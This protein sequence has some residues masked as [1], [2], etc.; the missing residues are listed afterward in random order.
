MKKQIKNGILALLCLLLFSG[1]LP[2]AAAAKAGT[3]YLAAFS[4]NRTLIEPVSVTYTRG[5]SVKDAL[6]ASGFRFTGLEER[7]ISE[8]EREAG[9]YYLYYDAL[10]YDLDA[11]AQSITALYFTETDNGCPEAIS[12]LA[13]MGAY[14]ERTDNIQNYPAAKTAYEKGLDGLRA[15]SA[16]ELPALLREMREAM[17]AYDAYLSGPKY[18][19][20]F[21]VTG[22][23]KTAALTDAYGNSVP[24]KDMQADAVAGEYFF[25]VS[26]GACC[27]TEGTFTV[28]GDAVLQISLPEGDWF[29]EINLLDKEKN[30]YRRAKDGTAEESRVFVPDTAGYADVYLNAMLGDVPDAANTVLRTVYT[31]TNGADM[32]EVARSWNS[33]R[34]LLSYLLSKGCGG[35]SLTLEARYRDPQGYLQVQS[36]AVEIE[37][38]PTLSALSLWDGGTQVY[39]PFAPLTNAYTVTA[40]HSELSV[41]A[42]PFMP[43]YTVASSREGDTLRVNVSCGTLKNEYRVTVNTVSPARVTLVAPAGTDAA[44]CGPGDA[45][46][47]PTDGAYLLIPGETYAYTV[48]KDG[49]YHA[50][51]S[52][53]AA[54]GLTVTAAAPQTRDLL[55]D[56][57]FFNASSAKTRAEY[58]LSAP[59]DAAVHAYGFTVPDA[60]SALYVQGTPADGSALYAVYTAMS[61]KNADQHGRPA[62]KQVSKTVNA[63]AAADF[64]TNA[65]APCG[66][67]Q[68]V[69]LRLKQDGGNG[70]TYWQDYEFVITRT[71]HL[72]SLELSADGQP[73]Q[74]LDGDG[75]AV[76][77]DRNIRE[78]TVNILP[79]TAA[80]EL[81]GAF[82]NETDETACCGGYS[83]DVRGVVYGALDGIEIPLAADTEDVTVAIT[84][85]HAS[86]ASGEYR[87]RFHPQAPVAVRFVADPA[88]ATVFITDDR[89]GKPVYPDGG[90]F[91]LNPGQPY[92]CTVTKNGY[93]GQREA[94]FI[95]PQTDTEVTVTLVP[96]E[97]NNELAELDAFWPGSRFD[98]DNNAAV[99]VRTP[100]RS[101]D[102]VL[103]WATR[104]GSGYSSDACGCPIIADGYLYT[105]AGKWIYKVDS[106][107][108]EIVAQGQMDH[109]SSF[110]INAPTYADGMIF[111]G[112]SDGCVQAFN[113]STLESLWIYRDALGGQPNCPIAYLNG[114]IYTGFWI[115]ETSNANFV[116]LSVADEDPSRTTEEKLP[117]WTYTHKGGFYWAGAY[118]CDTFLA[119]GSDDGC[120][121]RKDGS[122]SMITIDPLT[123]VPIDCVTPESAGDIRSTVMRDADSGLFCF[124]AENGKFFIADIAADGTINRLDAV[125]LRN[126]EGPAMSTST[127]AVYH[128]RAYVGVCGTSQ[129][130]PYSGHAVSVIDITKKQVVYSVPT[131]GYPQ[132]SGLLTTA[133]SEADGT[134]YV[135]FFDNY[136]PGKLRMLCDKPGQTRAVLTAREIYTAGS[137]QKTCDAVY[138]LFTPAGEQA[139]YAICSPVAD[140]YGTLYFKNDSAFLMAVGSTL[141]GLT[142][143]SPP[144]KTAYRTG[145]RFDPEGMRVTAEYANGLTRDVTKYVSWSTDPLTADD[146]ELEIRFEHTLYQDLADGTGV[147]YTAPSAVIRLTVSPDGDPP[148][149]P[150]QL[151][152]PGDADGDGSITAAD[153][154]LALRRAVDLETYEKGSLK[155]LA[156]DADA[157]G[158]VTAADARKI[159]RAAVE[160]EDP[161]GWKVQTPPAD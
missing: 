105:Y 34:T 95:A 126:G 134:V 20:R 78:Y 118:V 27:R 150:V 73:L 117:T 123:G 8:I 135:Y 54:D 58:A 46:V 87:L 38:I 160:L 47:S 154:R 144:N 116:C 152:Q 158:S 127:P 74:L 13:E 51:A 89:T 106:V 35:A 33:T 7:W 90:V 115:S 147:A 102:A 97:E 128:G 156:C 6:A 41:Q 15:A 1:G 159:L 36:R 67:G 129:F 143:T 153:A 55:A 60:S 79:G 62:E 140:E 157:D 121:G 61:V 146:T 84:L 77:F 30:A 98:A 59:F 70:V 85:R 11:P 139:Q 141:T 75:N 4:R 119:V 86:G 109:S 9:N 100:I 3:F 26:D 22:G 21:N 2:R 112:L 88:D 120:P 155:Y 142:V 161:S 56:A 124:T 32:S 43:E 108:G 113:A 16:A 49:Y 114:Y 52:F 5:Q 37:R 151:Y 68:T 133:Y 132:T 110:A 42:Q 137:V 91:L 65:I 111:V 130:G 24:V 17:D 122:G 50:T 12:L 125:E 94:S 39:F 82:M 19:I 138:C 96:A 40:L 45:P 23:A 71:L 31:G 131:Q 48:T 72:Y 107:T 104:I 10:G 64:L 103:Y 80:A 57:A 28:T 76:S 136:S 14:R 25:T 63:S 69:T 53:T 99:N 29:G 18:R 101:E 92:T 93:V 66:Y 149:D 83:A 81:S 44:L 148:E 145:E